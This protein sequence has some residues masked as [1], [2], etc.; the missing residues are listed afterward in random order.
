MQKQ[1]L[2]QH[3]NITNL[4]LADGSRNNVKLDILSI[5]VLLRPATAEDAAHVLVLLN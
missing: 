3:Y 1:K 5:I 2:E 4:H